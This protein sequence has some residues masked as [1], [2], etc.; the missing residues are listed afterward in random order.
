MRNTLIL[1]QHQ[2]QL[3]GVTVIQESEPDLPPVQGDGN[4]LEQVFTNILLNAD[5]AMP[6]GGELRIR[7]QFNRRENGIEIHFQDT[8]CGIPPEDLDKIFDPFFT[9][10]DPGKG[11]GLGLS[12]SYGIIQ[13]HGGRITVQSEVNKGS[14]FTVHLPL[15][16]TP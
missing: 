16:Q 8:G 4:Q 9:T 2:L 13:D 15:V 12:I 6:H 1:T 10:R 7:A 3:H 11:T 14:L 5:Q